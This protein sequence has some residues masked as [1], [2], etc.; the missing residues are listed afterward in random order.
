[1]RIN[2]PLI[3]RK[4]DRYRDIVFLYRI[5]FGKQL[6]GNFILEFSLIDWSLIHASLVHP[7]YLKQSNVCQRM[8]LESADHTK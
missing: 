7:A 3:Y 4:N 1:M 6:T 2:Y 8:I 5:R